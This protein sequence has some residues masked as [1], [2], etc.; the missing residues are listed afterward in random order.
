MLYCICFNWQY[1]FQVQGTDHPALH[2]CLMFTDNPHWIHSQPNE[3]KCGG[4]LE[5]G[6]KFQQIESIAQCV[7]CETNKGLV[8]KLL[9]ERRALT[10]GQYAVLYKN[11]ECLGGAKIMSAVTNFNINWLKYHQATKVEETNIS[12]DFKKYAVN[13]VDVFSNESN[14]L[15]RKIK[16]SS[17]S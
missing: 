6:F 4:I 11:G 2:G 14:S 3:L 7:V 16:Q 10:P 12:V 5:C 9:E 1:L 8:I 17:D 13:D 15:E